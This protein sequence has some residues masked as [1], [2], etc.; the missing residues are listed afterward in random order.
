MTLKVIE[1]VL[2]MTKVGP[3]GRFPD[4]QLLDMQLAYHQHT[5]KISWSLITFL[6]SD[7]ILTTHAEPYDKNLPSKL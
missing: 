6:S 3:S 2:L 5:A 1:L 7:G 4:A